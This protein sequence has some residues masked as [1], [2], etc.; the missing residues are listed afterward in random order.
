MESLSRFFRERW[1]LQKKETV[2]GEVES[3]SW[4]L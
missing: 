1:G 2:E 3:L 4:F